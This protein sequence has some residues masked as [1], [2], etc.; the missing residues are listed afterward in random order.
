VTQGVEGEIS[1]TFNIWTSEGT[2]SNPYILITAHYVNSPVG[3]PNQWALKE[4]Q[5]AFAL[6][7]GHYTRA[8]IASIITNI[9]NEYGISQ[10]VSILSFH[11]VQM[12]TACS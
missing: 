12:L 1:F 2:G 3:K 6:L 11:P 10:K 5:L 8:N 4:D 9:L 7:E